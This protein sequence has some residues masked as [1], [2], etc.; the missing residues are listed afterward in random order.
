MF[1]TVDAAVGQGF[2]GD[3]ALAHHGRHIQVRIVRGRTEGHGVMRAGSLCLD[4]YRLG[5]QFRLAAHN[6]GQPGRGRWRPR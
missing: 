1:V 5:D 3:V 6:S 2:D 4:Q